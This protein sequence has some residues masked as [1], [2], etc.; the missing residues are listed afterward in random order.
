VDVI[1]THAARLPR[2]DERWTPQPFDR[3]DLIAG[4]LEGR[5]AFEEVSHPLDNVLNNIRL[6][7]EGDHD[8]QFGMSGLQTFTQ[9]EVLAL[10]AE[11]SGFEVSDAADGPVPVDPELV[12]DACAEVGDRLGDAVRRGER[13]ILATGHPVGLAHLYTAVGRELRA[14][15]VEIL[16]PADGERWSDDPP[17]WI[18]YLDDLAMNTDEHAPRHT[19]QGDPMERMLGRERPDLVFADHGF[20]GAAI[21]AGVDAVSIADVNDPALI[22]A[23][24]Q[25][26]TGAVIVMD[27]NVSPDAYWPCFQAIVARLP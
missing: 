21:E 13:L 16:T 1:G 24:A 14:R 22:V 18:R 12:L 9:G 2:L 6:L 4:L 15:G 17:R 10:V 8:K 26:R 20:A 25:G 5:V 23:R 27:D 3:D 19:H 11:A 7:V